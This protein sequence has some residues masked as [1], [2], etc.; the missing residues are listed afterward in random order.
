VDDDAVNSVPGPAAVLGP[1]D[2]LLRA[3]AEAV[4]LGQWSRWKV[5]F[6]G[7]TEDA[8]LLVRRLDQ[9]D[10]YY[11]LVTFRVGSDVTARVRISAHTGEFAEAIAIDKKGDVLVRFF[12][13]EDIRASLERSKRSSGGIS[14][15]TPVVIEPLLAW[16]PCRESFSS[17][18]P[19]YIVW[20]GKRRSYHR[21]DGKVYDDLTMGAGL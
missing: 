15:R 5:A 18:L 21:V 4:R 7:A 9:T 17:F 1:P 6:S 20:V 13:A 2:I 3:R 8:P 19:F 14:Q 11:Y 10:Q 16:K 12:A